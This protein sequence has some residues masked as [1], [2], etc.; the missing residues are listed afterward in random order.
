[1]Q[2]SVDT[3]KTAD[4]LKGYHDSTTDH[5]GYGAMFCVWCDRPIGY[6][7]EG[8]GGNA[9]VTS[10]TPLIAAFGIA[11]KMLQLNLLTTRLGHGKIL[12]Q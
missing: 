10:I 9:L 12:V 4:L 6:S 8:D 11:I 2:V 3:L 1:M 7:D 5:N